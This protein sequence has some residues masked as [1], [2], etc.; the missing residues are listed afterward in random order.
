MEIQIFTRE[1]VLALGGRYCCSG[2]REAADSGYLNYFM[3]LDGRQVEGYYLGQTATVTDEWNPSLSVN[4]TSEAGTREITGNWFKVAQVRTEDQRRE[5]GIPTGLPQRGRDPL[6][7]RRYGGRW[8]PLEATHPEDGLPLTTSVGLVWHQEMFVPS[9]VVSLVFLGETAAGAGQVAA[10]PPPIEPVESVPSPKP[11]VSDVPLREEIKTFRDADFEKAKSLVTVGFEL[12]TQETEGMTYEG[13]DVDE[14]QVSEDICNQVDQDFSESVDPLVRYRFNLPEFLSGLRDTQKI[15]EILRLLNITSVVG[16]RDSGLISDD[17]Y[18]SVRDD[19]YSYLRDGWDYAPYRRG[20]LEEVRAL[21]MP[22]FVEAGS[23]GSVKGFEFRTIGA[24]TYDQFVQAASGIF[25]FDHYIDTGCSFHIH[26]QLKG[27]EHKHGA[28]LQRALTE[29]LV[30]HQERVPESVRTRWKGINSNGYIQPGVSR[31]KYS[32][33]WKHGQ[34]TWE[35]RC[36]G[37]VQTAEEGKLCL[38]LAIEAMQYAYR[39]TTRQT[40]LYSDMMGFTGDWKRMCL[41]TLSTGQSVTK[42]L[43]S[44]QA[45]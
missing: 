11:E 41:D 44:R 45:A 22:D 42:Y 9:P 33:V 17:Q 3:Q 30:E 25:K 16:A 43:A 37:N 34:G 39:V 2:C 6:F 27:V 29:Y 10:P 15:R 23:D 19:W 38:D 31:D 28:K 5:V 18:D 4:V 8:I 35:F 24:L 13:G 1:E 14:D 40:Q 7:S 36:F 32:F 20:G 26:L 12:E 21:G